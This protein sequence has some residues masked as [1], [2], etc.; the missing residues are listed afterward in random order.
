MRRLNNPRVASG[1][2]GRASRVVAAAAAG[3]AA[4]AAEAGRSSGGGLR[5]TP[6]CP[7]AQPHNPNN[8]LGVTALFCDCC[9]VAV[10][11]IVRTMAFRSL[12]SAALSALAAG[13]EACHAPYATLA[14]HAFETP[15]SD[16]LH[17]GAGGVE[18]RRY[19]SSSPTHARTAQLIHVNL[20]GAITNFSEAV[21]NGV[22]FLFCYFEGACSTAHA[23]AYASRTVPLL[24]RPPQRG[25]GDGSWAIDMAMAPS[26]WPGPVPPGEN[27]IDVVPLAALVAARHC[28]AP[29]APTEDDFAACL[30]QLE[31]DAPALRAAGFA[32]DRDGEFTPTFAWFTLQNQSAPPFDIEAWVSVVRA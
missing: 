4:R 3:A 10:I 9:M 26:Q 12:L 28:T 27:G 6:H 13:Y 19:P 21:S 8:Q 2:T 31:R 29:A 1:R 14:A 25:G 11:A 7:L 16:R 5:H 30:A 17:S 23:S 24:V 22:E 15:C 20:T 32:V 18:V